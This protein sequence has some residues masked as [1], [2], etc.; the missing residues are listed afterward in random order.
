MV[1]L[2]VSLS[3]TIVMP[4]KMAEL[5]EMPF[6]TWLGGPKEPRIRWGGGKDPPMGIGPIG[7]FE[8][9][10]AAYCEVYGIPSM[11]GGD[12]DFCQITLTTCYVCVTE[13]LQQSVSSKFYDTDVELY[14]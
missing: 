7:N 8:G 4:A 3:V 11:C 12:A 10:G 6:G 14:I 9:E 2:S 5:V 13:I 1:C